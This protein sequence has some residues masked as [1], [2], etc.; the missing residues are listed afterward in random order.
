MKI[1]LFSEKQ[2]QKIKRFV[3]ETSKESDEKVDKILEKI[4]SS[5]KLAALTAMFLLPTMGIVKTCNNSNNNN[6]EI[7][8]NLY[9]NVPCMDHSLVGVEGLA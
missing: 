6:I 8:L 1:N 2:V 4:P 3:S 5:V 9:G 7:L